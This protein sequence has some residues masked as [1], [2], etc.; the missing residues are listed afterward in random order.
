MEDGAPHA[1]R[2]G[3]GFQHVGDPQHQ[4][5]AEV[6]AVAA[7]QRSRHVGRM[8]AGDDRRRFEMAG[9][10]GPPPEG[11]ES[12]EARILDHEI[13]SAFDFVVEDRHRTGFEC[14]RGCR[15][16]GAEYEWLGIEPQALK[17]LKDRLVEGD[18]LGRLP[19]AR[20]VAKPGGRDRFRKLPAHQAETPGHRRCARTMH[21]EHDKRPHAPLLPARLIRIPPRRDSG[22][23]STVPTCARRSPCCAGT[24]PAWPPVR[25]RRTTPRDDDVRRHRRQ[26]PA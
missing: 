13:G 19:M 21:A 16:R 3:L 6:D 12:A 20:I 25:A 9:C 23:A 4:S 26:S 5:V 17:A 18:G 11:H 7:L 10:E 14:S 22:A 2:S 24:E 15:F 1:A 8:A